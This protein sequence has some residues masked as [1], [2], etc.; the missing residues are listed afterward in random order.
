MM[1][2]SSFSM[3]SG[4]LLLPVLPMPPNQRP[5]NSLLYALPQTTISLDWVYDEMVAEPRR[6]GLD[7]VR[8]LMLVFGPLGLRLRLHYRRFSALGR[9]K[10][11]RGCFELAVSLDELS[12]PKFW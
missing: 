4:A 9:P 12:Q 3:A 10:P 11:K 7:V 2:G 1:M 6:W 8:K 5:L